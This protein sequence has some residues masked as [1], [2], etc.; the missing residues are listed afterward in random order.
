MR[1]SDVRYVAEEVT[2]LGIPSDLQTTV[3]RASAAA[4]VQEHP[5]SSHFPCTEN[6]L[7]DELITT[8]LFLAVH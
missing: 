7:L 8:L 6:A 3:T 1:G 2:L 4:D 5:S